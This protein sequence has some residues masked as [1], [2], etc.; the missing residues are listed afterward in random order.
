[1]VGES[2]TIRAFVLV[3]RKFSSLRHFALA[4]GSFAGV[5]ACLA[6]GF[7]FVSRFGSALL[8]SFYL[9]M[10][11]F[12]VCRQNLFPLLHILSF[13][14]SLAKLGCVHSV[15][16]FYVA[17]SSLFFRYRYEAA[18]HR[19]LPYQDCRFPNMNHNAAISADDSAVSEVQCT[20]FRTHIHRQLTPL[21][22][23]RINWKSR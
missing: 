12:F 14:E 6:D 16:F 23:F 20:S 3:S 21:S 5:C 15:A 11:V 22:R 1:M 13:S 10:I 19:H 9:I 8:R 4:F 17:R 18:T 7:L 2:K